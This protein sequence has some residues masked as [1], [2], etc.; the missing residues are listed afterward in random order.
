M[1]EDIVVFRKW[2]DGTIDALFPFDRFETKG[3][4]VA[5][6]SHVGQHSAADYNFMIRVT[7]PAKEQEYHDLL[8]ELES[9]GY[10]LAVRKRK[11][12]CEPQNL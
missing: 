5:S 9:I 6:Y 11:P 4:N 1:D 2:K 12:R 10:H 8:R 3:Y 7:K